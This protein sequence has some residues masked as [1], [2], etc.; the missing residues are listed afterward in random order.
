MPEITEERLAQLEKAE[1]T[2]TAERTRHA[3]TRALEAAKCRPDG[4]QDALAI[5]LSASDVEFDN[6]GAVS[7]LS[8]NGK[9][10][11]TAE[12]AAADFIASRKYLLA[13]THADGRGQHETSK[14]SSAGENADSGASGLDSYL[15]SGKNVGDLIAEG[16][17]G[18]AK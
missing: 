14:R 13:E 15:R 9:T 17:H 4:V 16:W 5:M 8:L 6:V 12:A 18:P 11:D 2:L 7:K 3:L 10:F 1:A